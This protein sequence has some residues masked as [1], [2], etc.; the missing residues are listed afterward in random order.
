MRNYKT[1]EEKFNIIMESINTDITVVVNANLK[2]PKNANVIFP[3]HMSNLIHFYFT[4]FVLVFPVFSLFI[5]GYNPGIHILFHSLSVH[6]NSFAMS[7]I[8]TPFSATF[9]IVY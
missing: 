3:T 5:F 7:D 9:P 6:V 2:F 4:S 8:F 1:S